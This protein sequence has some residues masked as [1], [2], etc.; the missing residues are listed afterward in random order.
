MKANSL[1]TFLEKFNRFDL[2]SGENMLKAKP[3][4]YIIL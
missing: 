4:K 2:L 1:K 3:E